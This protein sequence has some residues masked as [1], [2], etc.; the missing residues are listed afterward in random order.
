MIAEVRLWDMLV[1]TL[2]LNKDKRTSVFRF[3]SDFVKKGLD[4]APIL[5][6]LSD[7]DVSKV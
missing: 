7:I 4:I 5:M 2:S 3:D 1:G 6:P